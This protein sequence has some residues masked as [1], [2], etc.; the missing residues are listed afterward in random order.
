[1]ELTGY[2]LPFSKWTGSWPGKV[3]LTWKQLSKTMYHLWPLL[4][5]PLRIICTADAKITGMKEQKSQKDFVRLTHKASFKPFLVLVWCQLLYRGH[6][7]CAVLLTTSHTY[8]QDVWVTILAST[9]MF[10]NGSITLLVLDRW[11]C[12][13]WNWLEGFPSSTYWGT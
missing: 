6:V 9:S 1:M 13:L 4:T 2:Y 3:P 8:R 10:I 11:S 12:Y 5:S 7:T